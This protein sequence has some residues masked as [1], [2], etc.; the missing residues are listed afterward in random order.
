MIISPVDLA[1]LEG[2][3]DV[4]FDPQALADVREGDAAYARGDVVR[5]TQAVRRLR[6]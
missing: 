1:Q 5:G 3:I 4:L 6:L 2:T